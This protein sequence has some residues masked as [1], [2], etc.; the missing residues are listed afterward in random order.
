LAIELAAA[1]TRV[2]SPAQILEMMARRCELLV[3]RR[4]DVPDRHQTLETAIDWSYR[5]LSPELQRFFTQLS[6][7]RGGWTVEAAVAVTEERRALEFLEELEGNS[8]VVADTVSREV[9]CRMLETLRE[10]AAEQIAPEEREAL[11]RRHVGY[12]LCLVEEAELGGSKHREWCKRLK[13]D[14]D[15]LRAALS[16]CI[17]AGEPE[18][19]LRLAAALESY[20]RWQ[21]HHVEGHEWLCR[22]LAVAGPEVCPHTRIVA[23]CAAAFLADMQGRLREERSL[24]AEA[25]SICRRLKDERSLTDVLNALSA[26]ACAEGEFK[27]AVRH[28][29]R[30]LTLYRERGDTRQVACTQSNIGWASI[31]VPDY[32]AARSHLEAALAASRQFG[33]MRLETV[34]LNNLGIVA[35]RTGDFSGARAFWRQSFTVDPD[36]RDETAPE[37]ALDC[38]AA[39]KAAEGEAREAVR[40]IAAADVA[41]NSSALARKGDCPVGDRLIEKLRTILGEQ[42]FTAAQAEG[43]SMPVDQAIADALRDPG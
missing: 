18:R 33:Y 39:L 6:V 21:G 28:W 16:W 1:R 32:D 14:E 12:H 27:R 25:L 5:L 31:F 36:K 13:A 8:L 9:R 37:F 34:A 17:G 11:D 15:N 26:L 24:L 40:L 43:R 7:F 3:S 38:L 2:L 23:L 22:L 20:W 4:R 42:S 29:R 41:R 35:T 10:Y 30:I 19:G